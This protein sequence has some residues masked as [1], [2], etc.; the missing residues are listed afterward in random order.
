MAD[1]IT[2][3]D[4]TVVVCTFNGEFKIGECLEALRNQT[5]PVKILVV[6]DGSSDGTAD[7]VRALGVEVISLPKNVGIAEAREWALNSV[8]TSHIAFTDDDCIPATNW[9]ERFIEAW[10]TSPSGTTAV[11]GPVAVM[12]PNSYVERFLEQ[13]NPLQ[14][15]EMYWSHAT[16]ILGRAKYYLQAHGVG[17]VQSRHVV[18]MPT[19][20]LMIDRQKALVAGG[21]RPTNGVRGGEDER[22]CSRLRNTYGEETLWF[23]TNVTVS[24]VFESTLAGLTRRSFKQ[25]RNSG[26]RWIS[27]RGIPSLPPMACLVIA[28]SAVLAVLVPAWTWMPIVATPFLLHARWVSLAFKSKGPASIGFPYLLLYQE[29]VKLGSFGFGV[30]RSLVSF[31]PGS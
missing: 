24:H 31:R 7:L 22:L 14:P 20:N 25:G 19:A 29:F 5:V 3:H 11:G 30:V 16:G 1:M 9:F 15:I 17:K 23:D 27:E 10:N 4:V 8:I 28:L 12:S 21:F 2:A 26:Q 6:D 18:S 13:C